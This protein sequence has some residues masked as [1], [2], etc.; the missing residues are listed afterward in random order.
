MCLV[1]RSQNESDGQGRGGWLVMNSGR[2]GVTDRTPSRV[3]K[4]PGSWEMDSVL[5][6][7]LEEH[8]HGATLATMKCSW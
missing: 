1:K 2:P 6:E 4:G 8:K 7:G 5:A 3:T